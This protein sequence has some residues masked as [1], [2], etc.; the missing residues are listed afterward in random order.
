MNIC[1][2]E[3]LCRLENLSLKHT[4]DVVIVASSEEEAIILYDDLRFFAPK[5]E[6]LYMP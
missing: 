6:I 3:L 5:S 2:A 4:G 1:N